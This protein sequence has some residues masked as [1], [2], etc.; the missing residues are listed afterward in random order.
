MTWGLVAALLAAA[1]VVIAVIQN[2]DDGGASAQNASSSVAVPDES[3]AGT[4][5]V[6]SKEASPGSTKVAAPTTSQADVVTLAAML[7]D[8]DQV[9]DDPAAARV[10]C[11]IAE[12][13]A[14]PLFSV[15]DDLAPDVLPDAVLAL[16]ERRASLEAASAGRPELAAVVVGLD[17]LAESWTAASVS[18]ESGDD[19][20][21]DALLANAG[22]T[23][24]Y[25]RTSANEAL[26]QIDGSCGD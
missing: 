7:A 17:Q 24:S 15:A 11:A 1:A 23:L 19:S 8:Q 22:V 12:T 6:G 4:A 16:D 26:G 10:V 21:G 25:L 14:D 3:T 13:G 18:Y 2:G 5:G 20:A 9:V